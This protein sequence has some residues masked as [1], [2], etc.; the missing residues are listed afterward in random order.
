[1]I[2]YSH[3]QP[4]QNSLQFIIL[5]SSPPNMTNESWLCHWKSAREKFN[6]LLDSYLE[7]ALDNSHQHFESS[8]HIQAFHA[9]SLPLLSFENFISLDRFMNRITIVKRSSLPV[10]WQYNSCYPGIRE[11]R[12]AV[13]MNT[14]HG[15]HTIWPRV[16][17]FLC[18]KIRNLQQRL[19][20]LILEHFFFV[21]TQCSVF[22]L[23][24][25]GLHRWSR[26]KNDIVEVQKDREKSVIVA[27]KHTFRLPWYT[28]D[29]FILNIFKRQPT[30][31]PKE[32]MV[33]KLW[34]SPC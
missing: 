15:P 5:C 24:I 7:K 11:H 12:Q 14:F 1:M 3:T 13:A 28:T 8:I 34:Q 10:I 4:M 18:H 30:S 2:F 25:K 32:P 22:T 20:K 16:N 33:C 23:L 31:W 21:G 6:P 29:R 17:L 9:P 19:Q 27:L 26:I